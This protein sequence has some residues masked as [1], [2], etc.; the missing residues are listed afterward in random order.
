MPATDRPAA[1]WEFDER[2][3]VTETL[4]LG[5]RG[6]YR[7]EDDHLTLSFDDRSTGASA[8]S[9]DGDT[10]VWRSVT[11][12]ALVVPGAIAREWR[13][14]RLAS[15]PDA[16]AIVGT[17]KLP[18]RAGAGSQLWEFLPDGVVRLRDAIVGT[19][20]RTASLL[21]ITLGAWYTA[22]RTL[23]I[24]PQRYQMVGDGDGARLAPVD[25]SYRSLLPTLRR[26]R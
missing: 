6:T 7:L 26:A 8:V 16:A 1:V 2:G 18:A 9:A 5:G 3:A 11:G 17:W 15:G 13:F 21:T 23:M 14:T 24:P 10:M 19:Y 4:V 12:P 20:E 22:G 25:E